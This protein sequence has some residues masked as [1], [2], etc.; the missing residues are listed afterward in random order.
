MSMDNASMLQTLCIDAYKSNYAWM[1][2][3]NSTHCDYRYLQYSL[4]YLNVMIYLIAVSVTWISVSPKQ[5][6]QY[7][8]F[9]IYGYTCPTLSNNYI[10]NSRFMIRTFHVILYHLSTSHVPNDIPSISYTYIISFVQCSAFTFWYM[11]Y[12]L[13]T[14]PAFVNIGV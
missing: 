13:V 5:R 8:R 10:N 2:N 1:S 14:I 7:L 3:G 12:L 4:M 6:S 11:Y 9:M